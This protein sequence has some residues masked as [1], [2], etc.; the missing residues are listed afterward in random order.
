MD[1]C[2]GGL[3]GLGHSSISTIITVVGI[4]GFRI[5]WIYTFFQMNHTLLTLY[6]SYPISW[7][8]TWLISLIVLVLIYR[9]TLKAEQASLQIEG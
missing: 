4:V 7:V 2:S 1:V 6:I 8:V 5:T 3:R 9:K